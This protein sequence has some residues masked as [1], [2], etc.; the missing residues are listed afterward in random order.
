MSM[1][2]NFTGRFGKEDRSRFFHD[3]TA[4][5]GYQQKKRE[6]AYGWFL[7]WLMHRG[8]GSPVPSS[9]SKIGP[10]DSSELKSFADGQKRPAGPAME[11]FVKS[12]AGQPDQPGAR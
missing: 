12:F 10:W 3:P 11:A 2:G 4:G 6:A 9:R 7:K 5:H 8:D 1:A